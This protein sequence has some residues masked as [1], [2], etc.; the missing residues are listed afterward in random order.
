M[1][2]VRYLYL[3]ESYV[4]L[5]SSQE[6]SVRVVVCLIAQGSVKMNRSVKRNAKHVECGSRVH[7]SVPSV[8]LLL[9]FVVDIL[10]FFSCFP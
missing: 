10:M 3:M 7:Q 9:L 2:N 4:R 8:I 1:C 6:L 5:P